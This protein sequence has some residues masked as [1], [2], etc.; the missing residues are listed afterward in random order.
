MYLACKSV[1]APSLEGGQFWTSL[2]AL[3]I[4]TPTRS[5]S[6]FLSAFRVPSSVSSFFLPFFFFFWRSRRA[7]R[8]LSY[9]PLG[10]HDYD[11]TLIR[12]RDN[13][14]L[15][16]I[17]DKTQ[18]M[19]ARYI[20]YIA[21]TRERATCVCSH[22]GIHTKTMHTHK[23]THIHTNTHGSTR[24]TCTTRG[25]RKKKKVTYERF[26]ISAICR[27]TCVNK[28]V[29]VSNLQLHVYDKITGN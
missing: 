3:P 2:R 7:N 6:P 5:R 19:N 13:E 25:I 29:N 23:N 22:T 14:R 16:E 12:C 17:K 9:A 1:G 8:A 18:I 21:R 20:T 27:R 24:V 15:R 11:V 10:R 26:V 4:E 28:R